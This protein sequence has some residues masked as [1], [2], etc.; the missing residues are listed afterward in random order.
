M[1]IYGS[2]E[3]PSFKE[4]FHIACYNGVNGGVPA[5]SI[6]KF[7]KHFHY[8][9]CCKQTNK[10]TILD[11]IKI[12]VII[13]FLT[14]E[15]GWIQVAKGE[16]FEKPEGEA[17][18]RHATVVEGYDFDRK[19]L[20]CKNSWGSNTAKP[21]FDLK[22][23][24]THNPYYTLVYF[25]LDSIKGKTHKRFEPKIKKFIGHIN[26]IPINCAWMDE[27]TA[28]YSSDYVCEPIE[29]K[30]GPYNYIGYKIEEWISIKLWPIDLCLRKYPLTNKF[31][32]L[33]TNN[34][35]FFD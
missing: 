33:I 9:I 21:R 10:A 26:R 4:C 7:E 28:I 8:G 24:A 22:P 6:Q 30:V 25:T 34:P 5:I 16:L 2:K 11:A 17:D 31:L 15:K 12:S 35:Y 23:S 27:G 18:G 14:S 19:C 29:K 20:I 3:A 1:R 13:S 32:S